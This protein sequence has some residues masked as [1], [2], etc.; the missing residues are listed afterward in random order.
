MC[1]MFTAFDNENL[2]YEPSGY[3]GQ[4]D[5]LWNPH[6]KGSNGGT[7]CTG[8]GDQR[9]F[10]GPKGRRTIQRTYER[11]GPHDYWTSPV[12]FPPSGSSEGFGVQV[13]TAIPETSLSRICGKYKRYKKKQ[14]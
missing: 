6:P 2:L 10:N 14:T 5:L 4:G 12:H 3:Q 13:Q 9:C 1:N 8:H 7:R 11:T